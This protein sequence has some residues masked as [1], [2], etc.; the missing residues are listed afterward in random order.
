M[1][2]VAG[3]AEAADWSAKTVTRVDNWATGA[4]IASRLWD[5]YSG[6]W[7]GPQNIRMRER[8]REEV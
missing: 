8:R 3:L 5:T 6:Y 2:G 7:N 1:D 4:T